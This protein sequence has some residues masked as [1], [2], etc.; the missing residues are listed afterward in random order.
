MVGF[1]LNI[2]MYFKVIII[3]NMVEINEIKNQEI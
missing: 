3:K 2:E 1:I